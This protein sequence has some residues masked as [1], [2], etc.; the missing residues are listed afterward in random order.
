MKPFGNAISFV[1]AQE[2]PENEGFWLFA[3]P[4]LA[5]VRRSLGERADSRSS[6]RTGATSAVVRWRR[7]CVWRDVGVADPRRRTASRSSRS[8]RPTR[9]S[10]LSSRACERL[11]SVQ[12]CAAVISSRRRCWCDV[13][14]LRF[15]TSD[16]PMLLCLS[17]G[18]LWTRVWHR[19][20]REDRFALDYPVQHLAP[21]TGVGS[22]TLKSF[23]GAGQAPICCGKKSDLWARRRGRPRILTAREE[24][25]AHDACLPTRRVARDLRAELLSTRS[26]LAR[27]RVSL[28]GLHQ[29]SF[30]TRCS[31]CRRRA[32]GARGSRLFLPTA[33]RTATRPAH[34]AP[35][36]VLHRP[37]PRGLGPR[38][39]PP[40]RRRPVAGAPTALRPR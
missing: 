11:R 31:R 32:S 17:N 21:A 16:V 40:D 20:R 26:A 37:R 35:P 34:H 39:R 27:L 23:P 14:G 22:Y 15:G 12:L 5:Q 1:F 9:S 6:A 38:R 30:V 24:R 33:D 25:A 13:W 29:V 4:R 8:A 18:L 7:R 28:S 19:R 36:R 10:A 3:Q 2:K